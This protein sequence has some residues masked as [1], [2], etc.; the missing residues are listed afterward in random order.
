MR[1][2]IDWRRLLD[3]GWWHWAVTLPLLAAHVGFGEA[4]RPAFEA[5]TVLCAAMAALACWRTGDPLATA[6]QVRL[7]FLALLVL[8]LAPAAAWFHWLQLAGMS[9][10]LA[11][12][13][14]PLARLLELMPW[15]RDEPLTA[16]SVRA[17]FLTRPACGGILRPVPATPAYGP[18][19]HCDDVSPCGITA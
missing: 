18:F 3:V 2:A 13:Y 9:T 15:N 5:A 10:M 17:T 12:G 4:A 6:V 8:G 7:A 16:Q 11:V 1:Y 19:V 14:C